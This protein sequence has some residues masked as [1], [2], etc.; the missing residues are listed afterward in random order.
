MLLSWNVTFSIILEDDTVARSRYGHL[1]MAYR[2]K[3][4]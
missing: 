4:M 2:H 1:C 3:F